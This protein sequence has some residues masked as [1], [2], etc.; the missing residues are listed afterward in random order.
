MSFAARADHRITGSSTLLMVQPETVIA[1]HRQGLR[2]F[3]TRKS[4][5]HTGRP[6]VASDVRALIRTMSPENPL[7]DSRTCNAPSAAATAFIIGCGPQT[8]TSRSRTS[9]TSL[10]RIR[11]SIRPRSCPPVVSAGFVFSVLRD[12]MKWQCAVRARS[13]AANTRSLAV[14][15]A[16]LQA[17]LLSCAACRQVLTDRESLGR[18]AGVPCFRPFARARRR[19]CTTLL[20]N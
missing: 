10:A 7:I 8:N 19:R 20:A 11:R 12:R 16:A 14:S 5:R 9:G 13:S 3:W 1:R 15:T 4:R 2:L 6:P 18:I 17:H